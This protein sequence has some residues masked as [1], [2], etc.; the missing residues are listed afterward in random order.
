MQ[1]QKHCGNITEPIVMIEQ[2]ESKPEIRVL[3]TSGMRMF[4]LPFLASALNQKIIDYRLLIGLYPLPAIRPFINLLPSRPKA[5]LIDRLQCIPF[6]RIRVSLVSELLAHLDS[7]AKRLKIPA[8]I[9]FFLT[10][11]AHASFSK[12]ASFEL[13]KYKPDIYHYRCAFGLKSLDTADRVNA[14]KLCDHSIAHPAHI[15][16]LEENRGNLPTNSDLD[17]KSL[18]E[19]SLVHMNND[20]MRADHIVVNSEFVKISLGKAGIP[21]SR[22]TVVELCVERKIREYS[23]CNFQ[24]LPKR[25][26]SSL[27]YAGGWIERKG[28]LTLAKSIDLLQGE[29]ELRIA[30]A[31]DNHVKAF[32]AQ[33]K[34]SSSFLSPL[35]YLSRE[36]LAHEMIKSSIFVFPSLCEGYAKTIQEAMVCGCYIIATPNSGFS[37]FPGA[38]GTIIRPGDS[39]ELAQAISEAVANPFLDDYCRQNREVALCRYTPERY[40]SE[41]TSLYKQLCLEYLQGSAASRVGNK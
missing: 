15:L 20:L 37:L 13:T 11:L 19:A 41:M 33:N 38:Y 31:S 36:Q 21:N 18:T 32:C 5:K 16:Y 8:C 12:K 28:V 9:Q 23:L 1:K 39:V 3:I 6:T 25:S 17:S 34:V 30:G 7:S 35:G 2:G 27:L 26:P 14:I 24:A 40:G 4:H 29:V 22:I 10:T